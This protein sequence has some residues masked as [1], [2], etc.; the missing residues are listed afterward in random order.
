[1]PPSPSNR[2]IFNSKRNPHGLVA[3]T[4][5]YTLI[6]SGNLIQTRT[7]LNAQVNPISPGFKEPLRHQCSYWGERKER[8]KERK[9]RRRGKQ[10][11]TFY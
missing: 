9:G 11:Q 10:E 6:L 2:P 4:I 3:D 7:Y 5:D 1:M 8:D